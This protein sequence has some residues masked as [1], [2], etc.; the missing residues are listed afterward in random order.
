MSRAIPVLMSAYKALKSI[1]SVRIL[2]SLPSSVLSRNNY[3]AAI[4]HNNSPSGISTSNTIVSGRY[5]SSSSSTTEDEERGGGGGGGSGSGRH[6]LEELE[7]SLMN[8]VESEQN[9]DLRNMDDRIDIDMGETV[10]A[11]GGSRSIRSD[12]DKTECESITQRL[13]RLSQSRPE[14]F[15]PSA[16]VRGDGLKKAKLRYRD[17]LNEYESRLVS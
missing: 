13:R 5:F 14:E 16:D 7:E 9:A 15:V 8:P 1:Q 11:A 4:I 12:K 6:R 2:H 3:V 10:A 17:T